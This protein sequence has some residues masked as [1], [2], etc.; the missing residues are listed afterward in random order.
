MLN[1]MAGNG[2]VDA[3]LTLFNFYMQGAEDMGLD[4]DPALANHYLNQ[5]NQHVERNGLGDMNP[6]YVYNLGYAELYN[7]SS[8]GESTRNTNYTRIL[9]YFQYAA[10]QGEVNAYNALAILYMDGKQDPRDGS[11]LIRQNLTY[12]LALLEQAATLGSLEAMCNL[13]KI[14]LT[15]VYDPNRNA[16]LI[17]GNVMLTLMQA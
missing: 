16:W 10:D 7:H 11:W 14:Y 1:E 8:E 5:V 4:R 6:Q 3:S 2:Q 17:P 12:G 15:G 9:N 13:A